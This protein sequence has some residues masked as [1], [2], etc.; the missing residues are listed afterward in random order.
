MALTATRW[1]RLR[2]YSSL[3]LPCKNEQVYKGGLACGDRS[4]GLVAKGFAS[5]NLVPLGTYADD[6]LVTGNAKCTI[7]LF[8]EIRAIWM[9]NRTAGDA[10]TTAARFGL[11]YIFD[12]ETVG[13]DDDTNTLSV[14]GIVWDVDATKG[15][16]VEPRIADSRLGGLDA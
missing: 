14:M 6:K 16:L 13:V 10:V 12:D 5:V 9:K 2:T 3:D 4:T 1:T 11:C 8:R 7:D 15:V